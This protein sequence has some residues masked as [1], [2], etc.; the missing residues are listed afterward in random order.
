MI[1]QALSRCRIQIFELGISTPKPL[2]SKHN[3]EVQTWDLY[4]PNHL[5]ISP[6]S[7]RQ[8]PL[9]AQIKEFQTLFKFQNKIWYI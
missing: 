8:P 2:E 3:L 7:T 9:V 1:S 4:P 5:E 6:M